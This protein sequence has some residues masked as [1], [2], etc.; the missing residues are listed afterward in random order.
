MRWR[1]SKARGVGK[2]AGSP[3]D[4]FAPLVLIKVSIKEDGR[5]QPGK[6]QFKLTTEDDPQDNESLRAKLK[7]DHDFTLPRL[8][9]DAKITDYLGQVRGAITRAQLENFDV[10]ERLALGFFNFTRYRLWLDLDPKQWADA[11]AEHSPETHPIVR[12]LLALEPLDRSGPREINASRDHRVAEEVARHQETDDIPLVKD[13][14]S[15]QYAALLQANKGKSIV[16][17]GPPGSGK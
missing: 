12:S 10:S 5:G 4:L 7:K 2:A 9:A 3:Q 16:V 11:G 1:E 17:I 8:A 13:A 15:T 6:R 14:D